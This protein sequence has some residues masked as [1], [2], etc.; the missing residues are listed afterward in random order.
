VPGA[1][2]KFTTIGFKR[3]DA[4]TWENTVTT[5]GNVTSTNTYTI[6]K[7]G[8]TLTQRQKGTT[9]KGQPMNNVIVWDKQ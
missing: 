1:S 5:D 3:I 6:S 4:S 2:P 9:A 8:K 7:D